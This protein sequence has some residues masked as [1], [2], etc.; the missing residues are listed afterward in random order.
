MG[1]ET[2]WRNHLPGLKDVSDLVIESYSRGGTLPNELIS[3]S[4]AD[5]MDCSVARDI[6]RA[7][8]SY[9]TEDEAVH[10]RDV[11]VKTNTTDAQSKTYRSLVSYAGEESVP[12]DLAAH[13]YGG[14]SALQYEGRVVYMR[15]EVGG[16]FL[17]RAINVTGGR[18]EWESMGAVVQSGEASWAGRPIGVNE[19]E[20]PPGSFAQFPRPPD[21]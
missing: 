5:W 13:I 18:L 4:V 14:V 21:C 10:Y 20:S 8:I 11:A 15:T 16:D 19:I 12:D 9:E 7:S 2:W 1:S 6:I 3:G 17:G